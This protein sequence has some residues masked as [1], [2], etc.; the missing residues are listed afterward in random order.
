MFGRK[1]NFGQSEKEKEKISAKI[2][3]LEILEIIFYDY[4]DP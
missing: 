4:G 3:P 1:H 2:T